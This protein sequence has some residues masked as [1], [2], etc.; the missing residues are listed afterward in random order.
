MLQ[1]VLRTICVLA[2][3][4]SSVCLVPAVHAEPNEDHQKQEFLDRV[5]AA[6]ACRDRD[7]YTCAAYNFSLAAE[8]GASFNDEEKNRA[9]LIDYAKSIY[10]QDKQVLLGLIDEDDALAVFLTE[11]LNSTSFDMENGLQFAR[12]LLVE[13]NH[14][15]SYLYVAIS[16]DL[17]KKLDVCDSETF[18]IAD[19][20]F[21]VLSD[22]NALTD[23]DEYEGDVQELTSMEA[24]KLGVKIIACVL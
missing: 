21:R 11:R 24:R 14:R 13:A 16:F 19:D 5:N 8:T 20:V 4:V 18:E 7:E 23:V 12:E 10:L 3:W 15:N 17:L 2:L 22:K 6:Y 9:F 1:N